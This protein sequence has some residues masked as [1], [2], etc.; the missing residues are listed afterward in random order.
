LTEVQE[1]WEQEDYA[2]AEARLNELVAKV[3]G[4]AY[5]YALANQYLANTRILSGDTD[6]ARL[7][8]EQAIGAGDIP[9]VI[10]ADLD[11]FYGQLLL[12]DEEY[13][14]SVEHLERWLSTV[15]ANP[16]RIAPPQPKQVF[17]VAYANYMNKNLARA[18]ELMEQSIAE[19]PEPNPQWERVYYQVLYEQ[20]E[21]DLALDVLLRLLEQQPEEDDNWRLLANHYMQQEQ[22]QEG[23]AAML[24]ANFV[25]PMTTETDLKRLVN[26]FGYVDIPERAAR[27]LEQYI[28]SGEITA[29]PQTLRQ[30]GDLW[31]MAREREKAKVALQKAAD[32]APD[33]RTYRLLGG[34]FFEDEEW[35]NA[36][37]A[38]LEAL[39]LGGLNAPFQ[40]RLLAGI[41]AYRAGMTDEARVALQ[42]AAEDEDIRPQ[43]EALLR[44]L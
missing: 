8:V 4:N 20:E 9:M 38:F 37:S 19:S 23:L 40:V 22:H 43:A 27:M 11:L 34:I 21:F 15:L 33:G 16:T 2:T 24:L 31:L 14:T 32:A 26:M 42:A 12:G 30:L 3:R 5:E 28:D 13:A 10:R 29:D 18:R 17:Y 39:D 7:A 1:L 6:G 36:Y 41:S 44:R 35:E 25:E